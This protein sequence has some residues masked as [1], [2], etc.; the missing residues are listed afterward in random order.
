MSAVPYAERV[1]RHQ[2]FTTKPTK[3]SIILTIEITSESKDLHILQG[4]KN[5]S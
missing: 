2:F 4:V 3:K 1:R 5:S